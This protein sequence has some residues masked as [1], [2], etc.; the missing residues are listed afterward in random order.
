MSDPPSDRE[1]GF[2]EIRTALDELRG[3]ID[4]RFRPGEGGGDDLARDWIELFD[5]LRARAGRFGMAEHSGEVDEFGMDAEAVRR[6]RPLLDFLL[7]QGYELGNHT[8]GHESLS[9]LSV[10]G[11]AETIRRC[12]TMLEDLV[13]E[14]IDVVRSFAFPFGDVPDDSE[15]LAL[16][17]QRFAYGF[18]RRAGPLPLP[19]PQDERYIVPRVEVTRDFDMGAFLDN[20]ESCPL[21]EY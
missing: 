11:M 19:Y 21:T 10:E 3:E 20:L 13:G 16:V 9:S 14:R 4:R 8:H 5:E 7:D 1:A 12:D 2:D 15:K 6:A 18:A 17:E